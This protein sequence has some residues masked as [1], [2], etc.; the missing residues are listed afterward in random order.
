M[1]WLAALPPAGFLRSSAWA[2]PLAEVV[3]LVGLA[4][5]V[6]S[7]FV[8]DLRLM[9]AGRALPLHALMRFVLPWTLASLLLIVPS[10]LLLFI[11]HAPEL[12]ANAA[13]RIKLALLVLAALNAWWFH[14]S[15]AAGADEKSMAR[16][17]SAAG[18]SLT[19]WLAIVA[20]GRLIAYV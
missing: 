19:L 18:I 5:L 11:A 4:L 8:V 13:F 9:G 16:G 1:A 6:G 2:Y 10:G 3:H 15:F 14:R 7:L 12:A 20:A 17:R